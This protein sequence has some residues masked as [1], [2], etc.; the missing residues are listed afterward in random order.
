MPTGL[1]ERVVNLHVDMKAG[2]GGGIGVVLAK[3]IRGQAARHLLESAAVPRDQ[4]ALAE[5][6]ADR[7]PTRL[8]APERPG[9]PWTLTLGTHT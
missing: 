7:W 3:Q 5:L 6:L 8:E 2:G 4:A 9:K 1:G